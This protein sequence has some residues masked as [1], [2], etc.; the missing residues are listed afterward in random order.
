MDNH[1]LEHNSC[2][3]Q[4]RTSQPHFVANVLLIQSKRLLEHASQFPQFFLE[5]LLVRPRQ[6]GVEQVPRDTIKASRYRQTKDGECF[7]LGFGELTR[8][9]GIDDAAGEFE[10]AALAVAVFSTSPA[11]VDEPAVDLVLGHAF[12]EHL[13]VAAR[14]NQDMLSKC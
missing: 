6:R 3:V 11:S 1:A 4:L 8:V 7:K 12:G 5:R 2:L 10:R 14:L 9:Y 13:G